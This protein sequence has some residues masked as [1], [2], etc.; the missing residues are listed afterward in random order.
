M[1][2]V[3]ASTVCSHSCCSFTDEEPG[4]SCHTS[5]CFILPHMKPLV[6]RQ[7][8]WGSL[9]LTHDHLRA[10]AYTVLSYVSWVL[11][12]VTCG[13]PESLITLESRTAARSRNERNSSAVPIISPKPVRRGMMA[14][15]GSIF[16]RHIQYVPHRARYRSTR[17][18]ISDAVR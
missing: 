5:N 8:I 9:D 1:S 17:R 11:F 6:L 18:R 14:L 2:F 13:S 15:S 16:L 3:S 12:L 10:S 7:Q 4:T